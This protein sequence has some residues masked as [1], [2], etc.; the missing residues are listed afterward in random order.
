MIAYSD[1]VIVVADST[2]LGKNTFSRVGNLS[3]IDVL[4]TNKKKNC[5]EIRMLTELGADV[6]EAD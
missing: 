1:N 2:K 3:E 5:E 6:Y 4:V